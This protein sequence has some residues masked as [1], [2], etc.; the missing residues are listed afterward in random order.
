MSNV[1]VNC[2]NAQPVT[3]L[4]VTQKAR[5]TTL[6]FVMTVGQLDFIRQPSQ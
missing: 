3:R 1:M 6:S 4:S 2:G 5:P